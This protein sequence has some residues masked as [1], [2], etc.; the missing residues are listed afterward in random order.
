MS[1]TI[2]F[3]FFT[4]TLPLQSFNSTL[5]NKGSFSDI[6]FSSGDC[7]ILSVTDQSP[8]NTPDIAIIVH[9][10]DDFTVIMDAIV[11]VSC[12]KP[13]HS[14]IRTSPQLRLGFLYSTFISKHN[15][16]FMLGCNVRSAQLSFITCNCRITKL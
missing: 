12:E 1:K 8:T 7:K 16:L 3:F 11:H 9:R 4:D 2:P 5:Y 14:P 15:R 10:F 6:R 13:H